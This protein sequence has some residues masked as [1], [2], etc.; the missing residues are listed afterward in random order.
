MATKIQHLIQ[1]VPYDSVL[2]GSWLSSRGIDARNQ[3]SY[4]KSGWLDRLSKGVYKMREAAPTLFAAIS[5][6]NEQLGKHCT[7]GAYTALELLGYS[8]YVPMGKAV[9]FLFTDKNNRLP[10]WLLKYSWDME[11]KYTMT[12]FLG[13]DLTGVENKTFDRHRL[14]MSSPERAIMEC[15]HLYDSTSSLL[16]IYYIMES[17]A[18]LRPAL[19]QNLLT[20][21]RSQKVKRLFL[22]MAEKARH[23]WFNKLN[24]EAID[25]GES[26]LMVAPTGKYIRKYN[27]TIPK[28]L[29]LYE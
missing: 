29:A 16:D 9:A 24:I 20:I 17:L 23:Q 21:C 2:F 13:D 11:I 27:M 14:L 8:Y 26:R 4:M 22:Y 3:Y 18:T 25:L 15:L 28:E 12:S 1:S 19:V 10:E 6:Y 5:S 7:I